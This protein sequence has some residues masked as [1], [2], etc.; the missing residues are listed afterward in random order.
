MNVSDRLKANEYLQK[1]VNEIEKATYSPVLLESK[2]EL[3]I[4]SAENLLYL[5]KNAEG[6]K[7]LQKAYD[8]LNPFPK[9]NLNGL[10]YY[11][12]GLFFYKTERYDLALKSYEK[13]IENCI[14]NHDDRSMNR[15]KF[16]KYQALVA[17]EYYQ[18]AKEV[19]R[20]NILA[21]QD[22]AGRLGENIAE[23]EIILNYITEGF[24][25]EEKKKDNG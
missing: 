13:G 14:V 15:L 25:P 4:V 10:Y 9:S 6:K 22:V 17:L 20:K 8:L 3:Y 18:K 12:D 21:V 1:A 7:M 16:V 5:D 23:T 19:L 2:I 24:G 11:A